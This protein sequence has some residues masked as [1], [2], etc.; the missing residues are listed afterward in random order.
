M[1]LVLSIVLMGCWM[2]ADGDPIVINDPV[3]FIRG[4][5]NGDFRVNLADAIVTI[6]FVFGNHEHHVS[7]L[8]AIDADDDG[9]ITIDDGWYLIY[10]FFKG[11]PQPPAPFRSD[12]LWLLGDDPTPDQLKC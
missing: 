11:G 8:D 6:E 9:A 2:G 3:F 7:C 5:A 10:Y 12:G 4:D 1:S